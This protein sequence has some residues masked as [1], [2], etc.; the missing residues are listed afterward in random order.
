ST[1]QACPR[2]FLNPKTEPQVFGCPSFLPQRRAVFAVRGTGTLSS[3]KN[4]KVFHSPVF[5]GTSGFPLDSSGTLPAEPQ[6]QQQIVERSKPCGF[7][8]AVL[9]SMVIL[10]H[11]HV[12]RRRID[13]RQWE[14]IQDHGEETESRR[15]ILHRESLVPHQDIDV[16]YHVGLKAIP[17]KPCHTQDQVRERTLL[18]AEVELASQE[19]CTG[20]AWCHIKTSMRSVAYR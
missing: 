16:K 8:C 5:L 2:P 12:K 17:E 9:H 7:G 14:H 10:R 18:K 11:A 3:A 6:S 13:C 4:A 15:K 20:K 19:F 1:N